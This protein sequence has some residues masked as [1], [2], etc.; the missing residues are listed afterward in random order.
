MNYL[1]PHKVMQKSDSGHLRRAALFRDAG[2]Y[3]LGRETTV[4]TRYLQPIFFAVASEQDLASEALTLLSRQLDL[5]EDAETALRSTELTLDDVRRFVAAQVKKLL[6]ENPALLMSILYRIDVAE[7]DVR[8]VLDYSEPS[9]IP[10][11]I[12]DLLIARQIQK[13]KIRRAYQAKDSEP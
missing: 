12:A 6:N 10:V 7:V 1:A 2:R 8:S 4:S 3:D 5:D 13:I 9:Q 11:E